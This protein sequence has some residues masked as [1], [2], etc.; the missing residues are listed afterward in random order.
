MGLLHKD[1]ERWGSLEVAPRFQRKWT[2]HLLLPPGT[3]GTHLCFQFISKV[4]V[5]KLYEAEEESPLL[6]D[7]VI[8]GDLLF[9]VLLQ[10]GHVA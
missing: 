3:N 5:I 4:G 7:A 10:E 2:Q 8:L 6:S 1:L 9:H